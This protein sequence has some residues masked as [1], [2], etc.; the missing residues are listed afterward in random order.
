ML[1]F[2]APGDAYYPHRTAWNGVYGTPVNSGG[3]VLVQKGLEVTMQIP[4]TVGTCNTVSDQMWMMGVLPPQLCPAAPVY[5]ASVAEVQTAAGAIVSGSVYVPVGGNVQIHSGVRG[6]FSTSDAP[7]CGL[8]EAVSVTW[9]LPTP[10]M[11]P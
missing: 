3:V 7:V 9:I 5:F 1:L 4:A 8:A 11:P 6:S 10:A 2:T